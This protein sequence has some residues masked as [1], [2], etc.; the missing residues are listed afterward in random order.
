[1]KFVAAET[2]LLVNQT[3][4]KLKLVKVKRKANISMTLLKSL[5]K[6]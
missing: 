4:Q 2:D 3:K 6:N 1:M 5:K